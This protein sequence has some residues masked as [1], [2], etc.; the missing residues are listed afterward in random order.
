MSKLD[1]DIIVKFVDKATRPIRDFQQNVKN[2]NN[3]IDRLTQSINRLESSLNGGRSIQQYST[4][5][6]YSTS[7]IHQNNSALNTIHSG[8]DRVS[9]ALDKVRTK[10]QAWSDTLKKNRAEM[11]QEIKN[12]A[13]SSVV[14]GTG[15]YQ[16]LKP[17]IDFEKQMSGVQSVLDLDKKSAAMKQLTADARQWGAASSFS[18]SEAALAQFALGSGGF[19]ADQ[20]HQSLGG[21]L[22]LAEAGKVD[23]ERAAQIAVG[24][25]NGFGLA[26]EKINH[27]NDVF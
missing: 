10:T 1:L 26:A 15:L 18:P 19:N 24:T 5:L 21:T 27:V 14:A 20:I 13:V 4:Q 6:K 3:S 8:Y 12:L 9:N 25:L 23:L 7:N 16:L 22:Q 11:H 2:T 17:A